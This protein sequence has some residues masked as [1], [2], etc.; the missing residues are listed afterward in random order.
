MNRANAHL[1]GSFLRHIDVTVKVNFAQN[2]AKYRV[3]GKKWIPILTNLI[4]VLAILALPSHTKQLTFDHF[5]R[6]LRILKTIM[7]M[8]STGSIGQGG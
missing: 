7:K 3:A 1:G 8:V 5:D 6:V 4:L 2:R